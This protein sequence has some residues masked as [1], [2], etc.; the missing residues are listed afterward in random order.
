M[1]ETETAI[2]R[3]QP[4]A[5]PA[6]RVLAHI[7]SYLFHPLFITAYVMAFL[8]FWHPY[9][10][11]G[12]T[13][14]DKDFRFANIVLCNT[15]LPLIAVFLMWR[16]QL[17]GSMRLRTQKD[18]IIPYIVAMTFYFWSAYVF[19]NLPDI[20]SLAIHFLWGAFLAI[21]GGWLANI[22]FKVSMHAMAMGGALMFFILFGFHDAFA[23]GLYISVALVLTGLV[24]TSRLLLAEHSAFE[25]WAGVFVGLLSQ[26]IA[27][28]F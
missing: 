6:L 8:I 13:P 28:Q 18:R 10:F 3:P 12:F 19:N 20:P 1:T 25:V 2:P 15:A 17:I 21:C 5:S 26:Y 11:T 7:I 4:A 27:W 23:S 22:F 16:L 24:C 9:A 14:R